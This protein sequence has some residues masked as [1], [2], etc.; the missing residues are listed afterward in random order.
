MSKGTVFAGITFFP[1]HP[2]ADMHGLVRA[3]IRTQNRFQIFRAWQAYGIDFNLYAMFPYGIWSE[4][5]SHAE[6][7]A[8]ENHY[9]ELMICPLVKA[10]LRP[11]EY[12]PIPKHLLASDSPG[13]SKRPDRRSPTAQRADGGKTP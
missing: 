5:K 7:L 1:E 11:E 2:D 9:G 4:S 6:I 8:T 13:S 12:K 10:Y 3:C